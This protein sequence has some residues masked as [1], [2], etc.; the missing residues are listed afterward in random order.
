MTAEE[1]EDPSNYNSELT[2]CVFVNS[3]NIPSRNNYNSKYLENTYCKN[4]TMDNVSLSGSYGFKYVDG[5][6]TIS[7]DYEYYRGCGL[8]Q[9]QLFF[10]YA[11]LTNVHI[12]GMYHG[13]HGVGGSNN[14]TIFCESCKTMVYGS[15][16]GYANLNI[17]GHS[18]YGTAKDGKT[19]LSMSD[20]IGYFSAVEDCYIAEYVYDV[21]WMKNIFV[22]DGYAMNNRYLISQIAGCSYYGNELIGNTK[23]EH[24]VIDYGR[25]NRSIENFQNTPYCI[26][27]KYIDKSRQTSSKINDPITQNALSGAGVWG[28]ISSNDAFDSGTLSLSE[29]CRYPNSDTDSNRNFHGQRFLH[30]LS[31]NAP[32]EENPIEIL[33]DIS[34]RPIVA[35]PSCFIQFESSYVAS[36]FEISFMCYDNDSFTDNIK[37]KDNT[38][39]TWYFLNHQ[40]I[41]KKI[42]KIKIVI[43]KALYIEKLEYR[44]SGY[45]KYEIEYNPNRKVGICNVGIIDASFVGR[46]FLGECGGNV[47]GDLTLNKD[48]TIKNIPTPVE[49][50]DAVNKEY[51]DSN[52]PQISEFDASLNFER[53][54]LVIG[55]YTIVFK[56][57]NHVSGPGILVMQNSTNKGFQIS[58]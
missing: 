4:L 7:N 41:F 5:Y 17:F 1:K 31:H 53:A 50:G 44:D 8:I 32:S 19:T 18:Y 42:N 3:N 2:A 33:I 20:E 34:N 56:G 6:P 28:N 40:S 23:L 57:D 21:Q 25:G 10:N 16:G 36:D 22:F 46:A 24:W 29:I 48:S 47:Y 26:G 9:T 35:T 55:D 45:T 49:N 37:V 11:T 43:T 52:M 27:S 30:A 13:I 15:G 12:G 38:D 39:A 14:I 54:H 51:V 58:C